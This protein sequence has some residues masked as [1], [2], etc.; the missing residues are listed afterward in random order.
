MTREQEREP[1]YAIDDVES[2]LAY[3]RYHFERGTWTPDR[4][5]ATITW[6]LPTTRAAFLAAIAPH[7]Q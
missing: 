6:L 5:E 2:V 7:F 3:F 4:A 1:E